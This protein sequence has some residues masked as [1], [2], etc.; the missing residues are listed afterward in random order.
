M[1]EAIRSPIRLP[2]GPL[3]RPSPRLDSTAYA[4]GDIRTFGGFIHRCVFP[5]TSDVTEPTV[6]SPV[7]SD[8]EISNGGFDNDTDWSK[9]AGWDI[10]AT[11]PGAA[12]HAAGSA[13]ALGSS[14]TAIITDTYLYV[15]TL[16]NYVAGIITP[17]AGADGTARSAN[18]TFTELITSAAATTIDLLAGSTFDGDVDNVSAVK[19]TKDGTAAWETIG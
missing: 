8:D 14:A 15:F 16:L 7:G 3:V 4:L 2:I 11:T 1:R 18:G 5:G 12:H 19:V 17:R 13:S 10:G 9:G 6:I